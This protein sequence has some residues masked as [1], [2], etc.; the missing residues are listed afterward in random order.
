[1]DCI[2]QTLLAVLFDLLKRLI[3]PPQLLS[4]AA[5]FSFSKQSSAG[6]LSS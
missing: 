3:R 1:M 2:R 4:A 6:P 5:L